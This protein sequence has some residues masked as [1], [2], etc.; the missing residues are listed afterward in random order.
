MGWVLNFLKDKWGIMLL[1]TQDLFSYGSFM[2]Y[3]SNFKHLDNKSVQKSWWHQRHFV[4]A[5]FLNTNNENYRC[6]QKF[7][8]EQHSNYTV[9][10]CSIFKG[11]T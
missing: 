6:V 5:F 10:V 9:G 11:L 3:S 2:L 7:L 1:S 8:H 4:Y